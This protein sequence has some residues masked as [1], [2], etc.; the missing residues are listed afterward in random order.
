LRL[1]EET[2][3]DSSDIY[4]ELGRFSYELGNWEDA[5]SYLRLS[6]AREDPVLSTF[7]MFSHAA[8]E[9]GDPE[10]ALEIATRSAETV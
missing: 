10:E 7:E 6:V 9:L 2:S 8:E 1:V 3:P 4:R 5:A